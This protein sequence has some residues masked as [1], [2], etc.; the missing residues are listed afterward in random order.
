MQL[1]ELGDSTTSL[2]RPD[3]AGSLLAAPAQHRYHVTDWPSGQDA[4]PKSLQALQT[5]YP[6]GFRRFRREVTHPT[7][8]C[9][10]E[11]FESQDNDRLAGYVRNCRRSEFQQRTDLTRFS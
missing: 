5:R 11:P 6:S 1:P 8:E 2:Y 3:N 10:N 4:N 9:R 7:S